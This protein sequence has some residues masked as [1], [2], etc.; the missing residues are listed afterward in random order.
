MKL[1]NG[2]YYKIN[3]REKVK[4]MHANMM[5]K[6]IEQVPLTEVIGAFAL[7]DTERIEEL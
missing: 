3:V 6:F 7:L 1:K 4:T 2:K 5:T